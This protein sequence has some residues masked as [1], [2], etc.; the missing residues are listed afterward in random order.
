MVGLAYLAVLVHDIDAV[1]A[2]LGRGL[3]RGGVDCRLGHGVAL[4]EIGRI[5]RCDPDGA[6]TLADRELAAAGCLAACREYIIRRRCQ[7]SRN[8]L[9]V[10]IIHTGIQ[11][12]LVLLER[13]Y[14]VLDNDRGVDLGIGRVL[15]HLVDRRIGAGDVQMVLL[16]VV[17]AVDGVSN[18]RVDLQ[19]VVVLLDVGGTLVIVQTVGRCAGAA[20][21]D[22]LDVVL[23]DDR[24]GHLT[25]C[26]DTAGVVQ[27]VQ[28]VD[29]TVVAD[30]V[31]VDDIVLAG[32]AVLEVAPAPSEVDAVVGGL[33]DGVGDDLHTVTEIGRDRR[34]SA[35]AVDYGDII[36]HILGDGIVLADTF[37]A[38]VIFLVVAGLLVAD[39]DVLRMSDGDAAGGDIRDVVAGNGGV[40]NVIRHGDAVRTRVLDHAVGDVDAV[41]V[42]DIDSRG[43]RIRHLV[44]V[45]VPVGIRKRRVGLRCLTG[46]LAVG[47][48]HFRQLV[49]GMR[50]GD[51]V[52]TDILHAVT[53]GLARND[54][55]TVEHRR[56]N[57]RLGHILALHRVIV[58]G[59]GGLVKEELAGIIH[60][61]QRI[62]DRVPAARR[63]ACTPAG[64]LRDCAVRLLHEE[65]QRIAV[66]LDVTG[67]HNVLVP[68]RAVDDLKIVEIGRDARKIVDIIFH[69]VALFAGIP[70]PVSLALVDAV[71]AV[72]A[73]GTD[74]QAAH[75]GAV[76]VDIEVAELGV[77]VELCSPEI[78]VALGPAGDLDGTGDDRRF[79]VIRLVGDAVTV[80][81]GIAGVEL[82]GLCQPVFTA[83][84]IYG[85]IRGHIGIDLADSVTR[86]GQGLER[87]ALGSVAGIAAVRRYIKCDPIRSGSVREHR[88]AEQGVRC[89]GQSDE[90]SQQALRS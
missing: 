19:D 11:A 47:A 88:L 7:P 24:A 87:C 41:T 74:A 30:L 46:R 75:V 59:V 69:A 57:V 52:K 56:L 44:G 66:C 35:E 65:N 10:I 45:L 64:C 61:L 1:L 28:A 51:A 70:C 90:R 6:V 29:D 55:E 82:H 34:A 9:A 27:T 54:D 60:K 17:L 79:P 50:E 81:A 32:G 80:R 76:V 36:E 37:H 21:R 38:H 26:V 77:A 33:L 3:D 18:V 31:V 43:E 58:E 13:P 53:R 49:I 72:A 85:N 89:H 5:V 71:I 62:V 20:C 25:D 16:T 73:L 83:A 40:D 12:E 84:Q 4:D 68:G 39:I 14:I 86:C 22:A 23:V 8:K 15:A 2:F 78:V 67:T 48:C 63:E 42:G